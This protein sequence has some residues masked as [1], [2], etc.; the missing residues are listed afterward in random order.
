MGAFHT[1]SFRKAFPVLL[2]AALTTIKLAALTMVIS[3]VLGLVL[4]LL[5][6]SRNKAVSKAATAWVE[7]FR[8][9]PV[10]LQVFWLYY[11]LPATFKI[12]LPAFWT[13]VL[14]LTLNVSAFV[15]ETFRA[16][17]L[18]IRPGQVNAG[19][20]LGMKYPQVFRRIV[21]PQAGARVLPPLASTWV[22]LF[23]DTSLV[24]VI[25][26]ADLSYKALELRT[27]TYRTLEVLTALAVIYLLLGYPQAKITDWLHRRF[28]VKE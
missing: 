2:P 12:T 15:S 22:S 14:G 24:S 11:V 7:L 28:E 23:K 6:L 18:S 21:L 17:I 16:G 3:L 26:I 10:L 19:L 13:G 8:S 27:R 5:R 20:A 1:E 9:T 25:A 4:A